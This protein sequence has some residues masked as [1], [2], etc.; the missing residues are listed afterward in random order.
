M[1]LNIAVPERGRAYL[2]LYYYLRSAEELLPAGHLLGTEELPL[3]TADNRN[4]EAL[5]WLDAAAGEFLSE[6]VTV[7]ETDAEIVC[8]GQ[9]FSCC[10]D[11]RTGLISRMAYGG[12][13]YFDRPVELNIWRAPTD[14]D[15][16][17]KKEWKRA[18]YDKAVVRA[19]GTEVRR[20][21]TEVLITCRMSVSAASVQQILD[22][23]A[24]WRIDAA[25]GVSLDMSVKKNMEFPELPRFGIRLF[26]KKELSE[27]SYYGLGPYESY[28]DKHRASLHGLYRAGV[29]ELHEDYIRPQENGSHAD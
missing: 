15:M 23:T 11:K 8:R 10:F 27:V 28:C 24:G 25:G 17:I 16:Y 26:L 9:G 20:T 1:F 4:Q 14:N 19:Y 6:P 13:E 21:Q 22:I 12:R 3:E 18:R 29:G 5:V 2:R 7:Q